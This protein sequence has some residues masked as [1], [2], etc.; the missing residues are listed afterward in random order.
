MA[1]NRKTTKE[2]RKARREAILA[3]TREDMKRAKALGNKADY[4]Y[5]EILRRRN[6]PIPAE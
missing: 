3:E 5:N 2:F 6:I 1:A 4:I